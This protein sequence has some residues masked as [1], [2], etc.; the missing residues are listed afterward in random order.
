MY[1]ESEIAELV[2]DWD[3]RGSVSERVASLTIDGENVAITAK[4]SFAVKKSVEPGENA[5]EVIAKDAS[6]NV[7]VQ[8][9]KLLYLSTKSGVAA[10]I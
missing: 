8:E 1:S 6:G 10:R 4:H 9:T 3:I 5:F 2:F 7:L